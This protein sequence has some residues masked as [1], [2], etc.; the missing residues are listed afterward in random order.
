LLRLHRGGP[1][2]G[3]NVELRCNECGAVVDEV[4]IE[5]LRGLLRLDSTAAYS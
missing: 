5:I 4:Q 3:S 2:R 1:W